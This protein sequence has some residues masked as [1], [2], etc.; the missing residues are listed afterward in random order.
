MTREEEFYK[1]ATEHRD[2]ILAVRAILATPSGMNYFKY[3][4]KYFDVAQMPELG[5]EGLALHDR[6]GFMRAGNSIFKLV[7][8]ANFEA[9]ASLLAMIEKERYEQLV[10][11][12]QTGQG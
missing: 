11:E 9:A 12:A 5:L 1:E 7:S 2:I 8:E 10:K 6:L 4:F 3:L